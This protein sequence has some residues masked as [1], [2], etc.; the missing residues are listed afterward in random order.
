M[1]ALDHRLYRSKW[2][3]T[4]VGAFGV[5]AFAAGFSLL[6][7]L[8]ITVQSREKPVPL[9]KPAALAVSPDGHSVYVAGA[10]DG[11]I[12][13][14]DVSSNEVRTI[15]AVGGS[16][17]DIACSDHGDLVIASDKAASRLHVLRVTS[18]GLTPLRSLPVASGADYIAVFDEGDA[19]WCAVSCRWAREVRFVECRTGQVGGRIRLDF[20]PGVLHYRPD[21]G[22][23]F[24]A[25]A[26]GSN[27]AVYTLTPELKPDGTYRMY[28]SLVRHRHVPGH[29]LRGVVTDRRG[30]FILI[31]HMMLTEQAPTTRENIH[32]GVTMTSNLRVI[33]LDVFLSEVD[34]PYGAGRTHF[35]GDA[36]HAAGDPSTIAVTDLGK[37]LIALS[38]VHDVGMLPLRSFGMQR[39]D[40]GRRPIDLVLSPD[41]RRCYVANFFSDS[42]SVIDVRHE[43]VVQTIRLRPK[44]PLTLVEKGEQAFYDATLSLDGWFSCHSCHTDGHTCGL[45][46]DTLGDGS[47]GAP[48]NIPT[49]LGT[50]VTGPWG[51]IGA[52]DSL[53][54]Q[55]RGSL[56]TSMRSPREP[57]PQLVSA[58]AAYLRSLPRPPKLAY[59][60]LDRD[61]VARGKKLFH[62]LGCDSCHRPIGFYT[63]ESVADVGLDDGPGG[64]SRF[65]PPSL[66]GLAY[67]APYL[68]DGRAATLE[69]VFTVHRHK[70][71]SRI[72]REQIRDLVEFLL[73]L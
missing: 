29:N 63:S 7:L 24:V 54:E 37:V 72:S 41:Q 13:V 8:D 58:L 46:A 49:L 5:L 27:L 50:G 68:H 19:T 62:R 6:P 55:V 57:S 25:D 10:G 65:N 71:P 11:S 51:W 60:K 26:F 15:V 42:V 44:R 17:A 31:S 20:C 52:F 1:C 30:E 43:K 28:S 40:V 73:S 56:L 22:L 9:F 14:I 66:R 23:L 21:R 45:N 2:R 59:R 18:D 3:T 4:L 36:G 61:R 33:P 35:L 70:V 38:G 39:L 32:W 34:N 12:A 69:E 48:K 64:N 53:G 67:T 47:Y 16:L